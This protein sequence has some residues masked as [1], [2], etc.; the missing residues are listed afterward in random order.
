MSTYMHLFCFSL[1][2]VL[3]A[4][5]ESASGLMSIASH[6]TPPPAPPEFSAHALS[7]AGVGQQH[8]W[9]AHNATVF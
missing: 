7:H 6:L 8:D 3:L 1:F 9:I 5:C 2:T 4:V